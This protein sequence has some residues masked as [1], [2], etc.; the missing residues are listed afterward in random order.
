MDNEDNVLCQLVIDTHAVVN[1]IGI[2]YDGIA[3]VKY[4]SPAVDGVRHRAFCDRHYLEVFV[5]VG[6][7][8]P[9][10]FGLDPACVDIGRE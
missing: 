9:G 1:L 2:D 8:F 10:A 7:S 4:D 6:D 3:F 5:V